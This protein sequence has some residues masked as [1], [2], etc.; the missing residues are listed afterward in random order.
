MSKGVIIGLVLA[1][2]LFFGGCGVV[3]TFV[4]TN[5]NCVR[6]EAGLEA[7]YK[8]NQNNYANFF[9]KLKETAQVPAMYADDLQ[10]LYDGSMKGRY[11][12]E[13]SKAV[14]QF[15]QE[16]NPTVDVGLYRQVQQ[17]I[18][19]GRNSFEADQ[20]TLLDKKRVYE[21]TLNEFPG[22]FVAGS[23]GFPKKDISKFDIVINDAILIKGI[24]VLEGKNGLFVSMPQEQANDK[25]WY[26]LIRCLTKDVVIRSQTLY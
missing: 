9:N 17:V 14:F 26:D 21:I 19:A 20:K 23:L 2:L 7:Q 16:H 18:E 25:K 3:G 11:G 15:I 5:N 4:S 22:S 12:A 8:Q 6:Q 1:A 10:K 13:G 24:N